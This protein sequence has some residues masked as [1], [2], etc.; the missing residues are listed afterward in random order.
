MKK[1]NGLDKIAALKVKQK[2]G[3]TYDHMILKE[4]NRFTNEDLIEI[5]L[6]RM[7]KD[8]L[9]EYLNNISN[10]A[11]K[12]ESRIYALKIEDERLIKNINNIYNTVNN[13]LST[14]SQ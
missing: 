5:A 8:D 10:Y 14:L 12:I 7:T 9:Y 3:L 1:L 11:D 13:L 2:G 6:L 4:V